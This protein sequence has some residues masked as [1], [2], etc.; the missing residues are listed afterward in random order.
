MT[1]KK[2]TL[3]L[4]IVAGTV[5]LSQAAWAHTRLTTP[6]IQ[7]SPATQVHGNTYN[8]AAITHGCAPIGNSQERPAVIASSIVFPDLTDSTVKIG[9]VVQEGQTGGEYLDWGGIRHVLSKD[10]FEKGKLTYG[11]SGFAPGASPVGIHVWKG[12]IPGSDYIGL[13]PMSTAPIKILPDSCAKSVT[14][15]IAIADICK[16]TNKAGFNDST[17]DLFTPAVGSNFDGV[18]LHGYDSPASLK[19]TRNL[20]ENPLDASCGAGVDVVIDPSA[21]QLN[22]DMPIP[23]IWPRK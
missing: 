13:V 18:G 15:R 20:A 21:A 1:H 4:A 9:G 7:E 3:T 2:T 8:A 6:A 23:G 5:A 12:H 16:L 22:A 19:I 14:L 17:V 10:A 11:R